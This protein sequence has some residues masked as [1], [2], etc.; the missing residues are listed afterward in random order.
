MPSG[1]H[2]V[3]INIPNRHIWNFISDMNKWAPLV[4]GYM[5]H[6]ILSENESTW[7]FKGDIGK[8]KKT[9]HMKID[10]TKWQEPAKV[11]FDL[12]GI[13]EKFA[14][15]GYFEAEKL[16]DTKTKMTGHL[17]IDA[18]GM[19]RKIINPILKSFVPK[20]VKHL[21]EAV[22]EKIKEN[23]VTAKVRGT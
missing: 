15:N 3:E 8:F 23:E 22:A 9:I 21:T 17:N 11:T 19:K 16:S 20:N 2:S 7:K 18:T 10:I 5:E 1:E 13:N 6:E 14:G 12:T 4:P